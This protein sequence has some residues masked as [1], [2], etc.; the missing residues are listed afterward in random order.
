MSCGDQRHAASQE[1]V[2]QKELNA[3]FKDATTSPLTESDLKSFKG[4]DFF[5]F[6]STYVV[7]AVLTRTPDSDWFDMPT[8]RVRIDQYRIFGILDFKI[9]GQAYALE[10]YQ[11]E[12]LMQT[13][14]Y[15]NHLFL[16]FLDKTNG[17]ETYGGGR[18]MDLD[19]PST[20]TISLDF[21]KAYNPYCAYNSEYSCPL[22][23]L[24]NY[25]TREIK[26]G[27]KKFT[28]E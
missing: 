18:Y 5:P 17:I 27:V 11:S 8:T 23:P 4:L 1:T 19:I 22:V 14:A 16:P 10:V 15:A 24:Q 20:D 12:R 26:A 21:N 6:D 28:K 25:L 9:E 13:E 2:F 7:D 3:E